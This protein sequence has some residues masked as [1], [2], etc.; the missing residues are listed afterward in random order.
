H[1][2][3][4]EYAVVL[5]P[6][7]SGACR[8]VGESFP[9]EPGSVLALS[10]DNHNSVNGIRE[11][12]R[13]RSASI[14]T[15]GLDEELRLRDPL[16]LLS[17]RLR[18]PSLFAFPAQSNFSGVRHPL[19]LVAAAQDRGWRVLLDAAS[20]LHSGD[21]RLDQVK[22]DFVAL[23]L[24]KIAGYPTGLGALIGR[25]D[26]LAELRRPWFAGGTVQ[27]VSVRDGRHRLV[28]DVEAFEDGTPSYQAAGA[29]APA[30]AAVTGVPRVR[31]QRHLARLTN[32]ALRGLQ[33]MTG[34][35][36]QATIHGPRTCVDRGATIA[37][38]LRDRAGDVI[39]YWAVEDAAR[40]EGIAV[41]GGCFCNPGCAEAA[42]DFPAAETA[43]CLDLLGNDF[44]IPR[45][46]ACLDGRPVGAIRI[47]F[48]LGSIGADV[49]RWLGFLARHVEAGAPRLGASR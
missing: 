42:F 5:T 28:T 18:T 35:V 33:Q 12:A 30:L 16:V 46:A 34:D 43:R 38:T 8:L 11:F 19:S 1:A 22:P 26:A 14:E 20:L 7:A 17:R 3:A 9:F 15:I 49:E 27:W 13:R 39:P 37:V 31:L 25:R 48:G 44:T 10:A 24:Y 40:T 45:F 6:N 32:A 47:S 4:D 2:P 21:L 29:V 41:R 36:A 23:S